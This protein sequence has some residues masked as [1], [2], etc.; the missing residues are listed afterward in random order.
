MGY[1]GAVRQPDPEHVAAASAAWVWV[2]ESATSIRS[3]AFHLV[4]YPDWFD[5][6]LQLLDVAPDALETALE[7]ALEAARRFGLPAVTA[8]VKLGAPAGLEAALLARAGVLDE[9]LDVLALSLEG[10]PLDLARP[11]DVEVR[12]VADVHHARDAERVSVAVFGG[13]APLAA[14]LTRTAAAAEADHREGRGG[15]V[16][17]HLDGEP[18]GVAGLAVGDGTVA[19]LWGGAVLEQ[20]RGRG[21]YRALLDERLR[22]AVG[23]GLTLALVKG[24]VQTSGPVLRRA[25]FSAYGQERSYTLPL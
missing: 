7:A 3:E 24:R 6:P 12:W 10:P 8:W 23:L 4:R 1:R 17:A 13:S 18:V 16:V 2:P 22:H 11:H 20:H 19:R 14:E 21:V 5:H 15:T 9:T 25:G